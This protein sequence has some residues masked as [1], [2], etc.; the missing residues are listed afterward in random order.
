LLRDVPEIVWCETRRRGYILLEVTAD[1]I[2]AD[3]MAVST[4][5]S[6]DYEVIHLKRFEVTRDAPG[7]LSAIK[8]VDA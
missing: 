3:Y 2:N 4:V 6:R 8:A 7:A 5:K 1:K